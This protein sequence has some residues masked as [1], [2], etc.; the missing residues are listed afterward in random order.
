MKYIKKLNIDFNDW[1]DIDDG[2]N[3]AKYKN[4]TEVKKFISFLNKN[5][6]YDKF[7]NNLKNNELTSRFIWKQMNQDH[8]NYIKPHNWIDLSFDWENSPEGY[9]YWSNKRGLWLNY[10]RQH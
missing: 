10:Y 1:I 6:C 2:I 4:N 9:D 5:Y 7:F 3:L 8:F